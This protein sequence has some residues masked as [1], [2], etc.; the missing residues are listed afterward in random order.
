MAKANEFGFYFH[1]GLIHYWYTATG[2]SCSTFSDKQKGHNPSFS[3]W[4]SKPCWNFTAASLPKCRLS[5]FTIYSFTLSKP[6]LV[7]TCSTYVLLVLVPSHWSALCGNT[8]LSCHQ[9]ACSLSVIRLAHVS[10]KSCV[11]LAENKQLISDI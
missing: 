10:L 5:L 4:F 1:R 8:F 6:A 7:H 3:G 11:M 9:K 2:T